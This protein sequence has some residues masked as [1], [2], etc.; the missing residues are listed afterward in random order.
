MKIGMFAG[1]LTLIFIR[2]IGTNHYNHLII[3]ITIC[4]EKPSLDPSSIA[5]QTE[6]FKV[7]D[8]PVRFCNLPYA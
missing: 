2:S 5:C 3:N 7:I 4:G 6:T 1:Y 8:S